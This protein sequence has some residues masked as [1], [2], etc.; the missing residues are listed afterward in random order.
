MTLEQL[1]AGML[2]LDPQGRITSMNPSAE[3]ILGVPMKQAKGRSVRKLLPAYPERQDA[4]PEE[5]EIELSL[6][7]G[8]NIRYYTLTISM[9]R[10]FRG[11]EVGRLHPPP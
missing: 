9:L 6:G 3:G 10:D 2:V 4:V 7:T 8:Q 11:L 5:A 1:H